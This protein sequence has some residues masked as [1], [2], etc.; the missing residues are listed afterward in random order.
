MK[1][2]TTALLLAAASARVQAHEGHGMPNAAHWHATD[3]LGF[4]AG[5]A[6]IGALWWWRGRK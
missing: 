5:A 2:L 3:V 1:A 4:I 6:V